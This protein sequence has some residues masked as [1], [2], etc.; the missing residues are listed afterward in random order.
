MTIVS[1]CIMSR[2]LS[3]SGK[4]LL[5]SV[6]LHRVH[7]PRSVVV[8]STSL[9]APQSSRTKLENRGMSAA[10]DRTAN[11]EHLGPEFRTARIPASPFLFFCV[12][13]KPNVRTRS[14]T[15]FLQA[16]KV[17]DSLQPRARAHPHTQATRCHK[18][19]VWV[20]NKLC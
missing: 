15:L 3:I 6:A 20:S 4:S 8:V 7:L 9:D 17:F 18:R 12:L 19:E 13:H 1:Y 2:F 16:L 11:C 5:F 10:L 14:G